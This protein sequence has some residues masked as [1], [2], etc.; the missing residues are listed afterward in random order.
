MST[1]KQHAAAA[2][3]P[4]LADLL[5]T[6]SFLGSKTW[7]LKVTDPA[8]R[9]RTKEFHLGQDG[10]VCTR[11]LGMHPREAVEKYGRDL[12]VEGT[13]V[14]W[15]EAILRTFYGTLDKAAEAI[16]DRQIWELAAD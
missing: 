8:D 2:K 10:K 1:P 9:T 13:R 16:W 15:A 7:T 11:I 3:K 6:P 5:L 4:I 12:T 14:T